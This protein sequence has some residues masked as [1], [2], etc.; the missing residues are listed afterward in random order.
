MYCALG[1]PYALVLTVHGWGYRRYVVGQMRKC[2]PD[3]SE[4]DAKEFE[5]TSTKI[6]QSF[7]NYSAW[8]YRSKLLPSIMKDM[9]DEERAT[10]GK[11][12]KVNS[13]VIDATYIIL[14]T[15]QSSILSRTLYILS[16]MTSPLGSIIGGW[17]VKVHRADSSLYA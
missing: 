12:G 6:K 1:S 10:V 7:S 13:V 16:L 4:I 15:P 2:Q 9:S 17:S 8:H 11:D 3:T 14:T 5:Y